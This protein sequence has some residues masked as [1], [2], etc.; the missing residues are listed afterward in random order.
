VRSARHCRNPAATIAIGLALVIAAGVAT[1]GT[2]AAFAQQ[3][4]VDRSASDKLTS[5]LRHHRLPLVGAQVL[6][7]ADGGRR[8]VLYGFVATDFGR[9]DAESKA[10]A[11]LGANTIPVENRIVVRPEIRELAAHPKASPPAE[12]SSGA[13]VPAPTD[14]SPNVSG[15]SFDQIINEIQQYGVK[16]PP[17]EQDLGTPP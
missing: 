1:M 5:Y 2:R 10:L 3:Y 4:T 16:S 17:D 8:L 12:G 7:A 9:K 13:G 14:S 11:Q 15:K 6:T